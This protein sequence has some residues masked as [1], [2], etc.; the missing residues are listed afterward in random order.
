MA[1]AFRNRTAAFGWGFM[2][3]WLAM[4]CAFTWIML[5][6]GPPPQQPR[7]SVV[8][9]LLFWLVG[10]PAAVHVF[11]IPIVHVRVHG[12]G[13]VSVRKRYL[14]GSVEHEIG[15]SGCAQVRLVESTD[16]DGDPYF[17]A[18]LRIDGGVELDIWEGHDRADGEAVVARFRN[19]LR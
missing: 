9:L 19:A 7:L 18:R 2:I 14:I 17:H 10:V 3:V 1:Q 6:D 12:R 11:A 5:R 13:R 4:L 16:S 15:Q 8:A